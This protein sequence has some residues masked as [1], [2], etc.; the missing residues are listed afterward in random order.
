MINPS[1][2]WPR[3]RGCATAITPTRSTGPRDGERLP[4]RD[5]RAHPVYGTSGWLWMTSPVLCPRINRNINARM[6]AI[7]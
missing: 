5:E 7:R 6:G 2:T 1:S 4:Q 3:E